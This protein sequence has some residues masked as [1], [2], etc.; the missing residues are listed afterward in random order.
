MSELELGTVKTSVELKY[1]INPI[2]ES[3]VSPETAGDLNIKKLVRKDFPFQIPCA[4]WLFGYGNPFSC[5]TV[6]F[7]FAFIY[8]LI[9]NENFW[10]YNLAKQQLWACLCVIAY[11]EIQ[12]IGLPDASNNTYIAAYVVSFF[13]PPLIHISTYYT[14]IRNN[15]VLNDFVV[16]TSVVFI[17]MV[18]IIDAYVYPLP[19]S[20]K[21]RE[22]LISRSSDSQHLSNYRGE[23]FANRASEAVNNIHESTDDQVKVIADYSDSG[24]SREVSADLDLFDT[25]SAALSSSEFNDEWL[26]SGATSSTPTRNTLGQSTL[27]IADDSHTQ[28]TTITTIRE[29]FSQ[30]FASHFGANVTVIEP[31]SACRMNWILASKKQDSPTRS[32]S[33]P[34]V[35]NNSNSSNSSSI[36]SSSSCGACNLLLHFFTHVVVLP[37][38]TFNKYSPRGVVNVD[39]RIQVWLTVSFNILFNLYYYFLMFFTKYFRENVRT[40]N[41]RVALFCLFILVGTVFRVF[42]K[43]IGLMIDRGKSKTSSMY[44]VG[45]VMCLMFYY[46][47]YRVLFESI[48]SFY[49][50]G[51][52]QLIHLLSEWILYPIRASTTVYRWLQYLEEAVPIF[53]GSILVRG[54][55]HKDWLCFICLDFGVRCSI[56]IC[57]GIA[58]ALLLLLIAYVPWIDNSLK[59]EGYGLKLS[60]AFISLAVVMELIN[61]YIMNQI[62]FVPQGLSVV[63]KV[64]HCFS[65]PR[66]AFISMIVA[67]NLFINPMY[68]FATENVWKN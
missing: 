18:Y 9:P 53:R 55:N 17:M 49:E 56:M 59:Q 25:F 41:Q 28:T 24:Q 31:D 19:E 48:N 5:F 13:I 63:Q 58:I 8:V 62:F 57:A 40:D 22:R 29:T 27:P 37:R 20:I 10:F 66:F 16:T 2:H 65:Q 67:A 4:T 15:Y 50:F 30:T 54:T 23:T 36:I 52:F 38:Y 51:L 47:F 34:H 12:E 68:A 32:S 3:P 46:T 64:R 60:M 26:N 44:F 7:F 33:K 1:E 45:E 21:R 14:T 35:N 39:R 43:R 61:A 6:S 42:M 11:T